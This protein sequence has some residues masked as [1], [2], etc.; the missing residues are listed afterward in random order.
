MTEM[1][2]TLLRNGC[3]LTLDPA[4]GNFRSADIL[5]DGSRIEAVG[6]DLPV[7][8]ADVIDA[9]NMIVMPG[10]ID[11]HRHIWEGI[12]KNI[13]ADAL[14]DEYFRDI[15]GV[16]APVYRPHDAYVG[17][18]VSALGAID[19]GVTLATVG[20]WP[21]VRFGVALPAAVWMLIS[22]GSSSSVPG[23]TSAKT[24]V[25]PA[26]TTQ[27][28]LAANVSGGTITSSPG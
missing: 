14:L 1:A 7:T 5:I 13:A 11:T 3:V 18:L 28:A 21:N 16:L 20:P 26:Y 4:L 23:S 22:S 27:L 9:A 6:P 15:L 19:A 25:A 10:F 17:N 2:K 12:L 24:G 8:G